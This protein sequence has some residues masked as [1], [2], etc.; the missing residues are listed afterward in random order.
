[1]TVNAAYTAA[2]EHEAGRLAP[3]FRADLRVFADDPLT[4]GRDRTAGSAGAVDRPRRQGH[5]PGRGLVGQA[6]RRARVRG[7]PR[8]S[9]DPRSTS[10][11]LRWP[12]G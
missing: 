1:M 8:R 6:L 11:Q 12:G 5:V 7:T 2:D 9:W 10:G 3:G 4:T